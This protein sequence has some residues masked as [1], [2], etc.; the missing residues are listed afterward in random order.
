[1]VGDLSARGNCTVPLPLS[2]IF[3]F[4]LRLFDV[5]RFC[6]FFSPFFSFLL[7]LLS[8]FFFSFLRCLSLVVVPIPIRGGFFLLF[9]V[10]RVAFLFSPPVIAFL[11]FFVFAVFVSSCS[12]DSDL[13]SGSDSIR[14]ANPNYPPWSVFPFHFQ[15]WGR[16]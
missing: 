2:V 10:R 8:R 4:V 1:M 12:S 5:L 13:D 11:L 16:F 15:F 3:P 9:C 7:S 14:I 6:L